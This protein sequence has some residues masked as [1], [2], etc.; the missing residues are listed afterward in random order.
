MT[1]TLEFQGLHGELRRDEPMSRHVSWRAGGKADRFYVPEDMEDLATF[2]RQLPPDEPVL[3]V[4][5]G[6]NLLVRDGGWRG[7]V[8]MTHAAAR[9]PRM[10]AGLIYAEA[11]VASPKVARFAAMHDLEG[12]EFLAGVP[13]SVGGALAMNAGCY[14][15]ET[16]DIVERVATIDRRGNLVERGKEAFEIGYR[17]CAPR[18]A[19]EEWFAAAWFRLEPGDGETSRSVMKELLGR[20]IATQPLQLPNAGSVFRNPPRDHAARLIEACGLKGFARGAARVSEKHANFIVNPKGAASAADIEG[21][22][23]HIQRIVYQMKGVALQTE[24]RIVGEPA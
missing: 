7:T 23:H 4:G 19:R 8:V 17:H 2:L 15:G 9:R 20:R 11:G 24:V 10:D 12:A 1:A 6:S 21:L 18:P 14:G 16:W 5:L 22:I 3:F 13:G